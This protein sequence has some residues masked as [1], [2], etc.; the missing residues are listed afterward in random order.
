[1][2]Q[3]ALNGGTIDSA[4][5]IIDVRYLKQPHVVDTS[6]QGP[7]LIASQVIFFIRSVLFFLPK[8]KRKCFVSRK[9][10]TFFLNSY[11]KISLNLE[12]F[13]ILFVGLSILRG[14]Y[15]Y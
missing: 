14:M 1:M 9:P 8:K 13:K 7:I 15:T 11:F 2:C 3:A 4:P 10:L 6:G 12:H 5:A